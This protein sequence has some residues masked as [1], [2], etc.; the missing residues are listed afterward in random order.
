MDASQSA[1]KKTTGVFGIES[2]YLPPVEHLVI[3]LHYPDKTE[4]YLKENPPMFQA[5]TGVMMQNPPQKI[6]MKE[7]MKTRSKVPTECFTT[8]V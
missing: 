4:I 3:F 1:A 6:L 7:R 8:F 2:V 5:F